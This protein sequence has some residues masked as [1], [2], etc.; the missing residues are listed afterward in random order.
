MSEDSSRKQ[1]RQEEGKRQ[2]V[3]ISCGFLKIL[4]DSGRDTK[5]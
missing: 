5:R 3:P 2:E 1:K 4:E